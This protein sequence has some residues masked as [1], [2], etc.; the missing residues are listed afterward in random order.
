MIIWPILILSICFA[1][2]AGIVIAHWQL[3]KP[4]PLINIIAMSFNGGVLLLVLLLSL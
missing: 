2:N 4:A 3:K 1:L